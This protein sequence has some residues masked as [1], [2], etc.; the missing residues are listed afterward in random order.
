MSDLSGADTG[1]ELHSFN[2]NTV[3]MNPNVD[4][5]P[6]TTNY[7]ES[8]VNAGCSPTCPGSLPG[9]DTSAANGG[10]L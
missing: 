1:Y 2:I 7:P 6:G 10:S 9:G 8:A 4:I 3:G 5:H